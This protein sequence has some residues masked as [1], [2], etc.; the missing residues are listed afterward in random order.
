MAPGSTEES[1]KLSRPF[2]TYLG[3][4]SSKIQLDATVML[5][6][7]HYTPAA[8]WKRSRPLSNS[9]HSCMR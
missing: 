3:G 6:Q 2:E 1:A 9:E 7:G 5:V 8:T 4:G